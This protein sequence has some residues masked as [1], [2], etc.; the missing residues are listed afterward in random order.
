MIG[1]VDYDTGNIGSVLNMLKKVGAQAIASRTTV[2]K[3]STTT[4]H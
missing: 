4:D 3:R 2:S 1:V